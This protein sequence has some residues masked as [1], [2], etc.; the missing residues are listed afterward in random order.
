MYL[1]IISII[2][3]II[4]LGIYAYLKNHNNKHISK[5]NLDTLI[6]FM[7]L[8]GFIGFTLLLY[9]LILFLP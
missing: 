9:G 5:S 2:F 8:L 4:S 6:L 3:I 7:T 1:I